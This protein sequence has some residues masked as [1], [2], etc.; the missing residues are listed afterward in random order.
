MRFIDK[1][2]KRGGGEESPGSLRREARKTG[3][4]KREDV[5]YDD[6]AS[7]QSR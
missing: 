6:Q 4:T 5:Y 7:R 1:K 2:E 3:C